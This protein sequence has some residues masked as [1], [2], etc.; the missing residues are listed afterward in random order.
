VSEQY[1]VI[2]NDYYTQMGEDLNSDLFPPVRPGSNLH[3]SVSEDMI[4]DISD[5]SARL[6]LGEFARYS[7]VFKQSLTISR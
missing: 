2:A 6:E 4:E 5:L 7:T 1:Q 3:Y